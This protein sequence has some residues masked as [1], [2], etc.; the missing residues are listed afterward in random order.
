MIYRLQRS[1]WI[2]R[3]RSEVFP[4]FADAGKLA[5]ITPPELNFRILTPLPIEMKVGALIDYRLAL[6]GVAFSWQTRVTQ[7]Q[8]DEGFVDE[9]VHGPYKQW[10]HTHRFESYRG[11]TLMDDIVDY[12][13][14]LGP[15]GRLAHPVVRYQLDRIF[16]FRRQVMHKHF[17]PAIATE[18]G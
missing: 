18:P 3:P 4:F 10:I 16:D 12:A 11:G 9:Q 6:F 13:L 17:P 15:L 7:W 5:L 8:P 1:Q 2:S 14:P